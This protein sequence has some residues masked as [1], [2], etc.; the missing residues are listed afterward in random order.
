MTEITNKNKKTAGYN[1]LGG[2][3]KANRNDN[4]L[5]ITPPECPH[6]LMEFLNLDKS[7]TVWE[8]CDAGDGGIR[9]ARLQSPKI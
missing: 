1:I 6:A 7:I 3:P 5:Y 8:C 4:D 9:I 2:G